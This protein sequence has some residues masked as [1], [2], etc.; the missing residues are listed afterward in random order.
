MLL[1]DLSAQPEIAGIVPLRCSNTFHIRHQDRVSCL[2]TAIQTEAWLVCVAFCSGGDSDRPAG[3]SGWQPAALHRPGG[4]GCYLQQQPP[5][6]TSLTHPGPGLCLRSP[7][8][9]CPVPLSHVS[10]HRGQAY[11]P[12]AMCKPPLSDSC[13]P[14]SVSGILH[15]GFTL[16]EH[17]EL[18]ACMRLREGWEAWSTSCQKCGGT[19]DR[20][21]DISVT[22]QMN[23]KSSI[24]PLLHT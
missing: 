1:E 14:Q 18:V 5:A 21:Q 4:G 13:L 15:L 9:F 19:N 8:S 23:G 24:L 20:M 3:A 6:S 7:S 16:T 17:D 10:Q 22:G 11:K 12:F 2:V